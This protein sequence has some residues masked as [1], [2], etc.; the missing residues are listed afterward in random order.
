MPETVTSRAIA[1]AAR[2]ARRI[3]GEPVTF[4]RDATEISVAFARRGSTNWNT[5]A[6]FNGSRVGDRSVD[7]LIDVEDLVDGNGD[8]ISAPQ[9][10]DTITDADGTVYRA[11]PFGTADQLWQWHDRN[12]Q[13]TYRIHTKERT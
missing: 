2:V 7:W 10:G 6:V 3:T 4:T 5:D 12:G 8:Q 11:M 1:A 9:R 13:T